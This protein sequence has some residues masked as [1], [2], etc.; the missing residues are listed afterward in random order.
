MNDDR[1]ARIWEGLRAHM[2]ELGALTPPADLRAV[3]ERSARRDSSNR[4]L[5]AVLALGAVLAVGLLARSGLLPAFSSGPSA[6]PRESGTPGLSALNS[7]T[8]VL[9]LFVNGASVKE[10]QPGTQVEIEASALPPLPWDAEVRLPSGRPLVKLTVRSGDV[11]E[12]SGF[13]KGDGARVDLSCGRIDLW[14]GPPLLGPAPGPGTPGDCDDSTA[15]DPQASSSLEP[16]VSLPPPGGTCAAENFVLGTPV[17]DGPGYPTLGSSDDFVRLPLRNEGEECFLNLP[18]TIGVASA[19][20]PFEPVNVLNAG[21]ATAFSVPVA[22]NVQ[23]VL[24]D[25]WPTGSGAGAFT[26]PPCPDPIEDVSRIELPFASGS[27]Q[28]DVPSVWP[29]ACPEPASVSMTFV[30]K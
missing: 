25:S 3:R 22:G 24:G 10:L 18:A 30:T 16:S 4:L 20:G 13:Q 11:I 7:T 21:L 2:D 15:V 14:S 29:E 8:K 19:T 12:A 9:M 1:D 26:L 17:D 6:S 27:L 5:P 23:I 28:I